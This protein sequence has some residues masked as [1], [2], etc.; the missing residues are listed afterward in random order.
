MLDL[1]CLNYIIYYIIVIAIGNFIVI[2]YFN[3]VYIING[4]LGKMYMSLKLSK[5]K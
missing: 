2:N 4:R 5:K 3:C 1:N